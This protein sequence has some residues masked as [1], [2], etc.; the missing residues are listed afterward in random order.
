M[1]T[2]QDFHGQA[3]AV[4]GLGRS[5][6]AAARALAAGGAELRAWDDDPKRRDAA[7][8]DG[9]PLRELDR[10]DWSDVA[11]LVLSPGIP[12]EFPAP[13]PVATRARAAGCDIVCDVDLLGRAVPE[14]RYLGVTGTNG[15]STVT[16]LLGHILETAGA[17]VAAGGNIGLP[18][19]ELARLGAQ[20]WYVLEMSSYQLERTFSITFEVAVLLNITA[21]HLERHGGLAGYVAAKRLI[22]RGQA[23]RHTAVVG[24]DDDQSRAVYEALAAEGG[25]RLVPISG[26]RAT[27]G[28]VYVLDG[29]L[30]DARRGEARAVAEIGRIPTLPGRHNGQNAAAAYAAA[31][32]AGVGAETIA[33]ALESYPGL[34]H[35]QQLVAVVDGITYVNDS[36]ATNVAAAAR[37]LACYD[38]VYWIA[39][40]RTKAGGI[41]GLEPWLGRVVHAFLIGEAADDLAAALAGRAPCTRSGDLATAVAQAHAMAAADG[42]PGATVLLS[43]A[44]ASFDQFENFEARGARFAELVEALPGRRSS[45]AEARA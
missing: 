7:A 11:V 1:I 4:M 37:A 42:R 2:V 8:A 6:L 29:V 26:E 39:G 20:G 10:D 15:K 13:H 25:R 17:E 21:D 28:G 30:I 35:R 41:E 18:A 44:C 33:R 31:R 23:P 14:A 34:P 27:A 43:P 45:G 3:V 32:A 24:V 40:G 12:H 38:A 36:K 22:F 9:L 19:L 16:A 5:G